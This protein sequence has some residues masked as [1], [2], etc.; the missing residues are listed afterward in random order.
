MTIQLLNDLLFCYNNTATTYLV[1]SKYQFH[2]NYVLTTMGRPKI[3][4]FVDIVS[5]FAYLGFYAL[6]VS[7]RGLA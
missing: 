2:A 5:P 3:T 7:S 4:L 6:K 1:L